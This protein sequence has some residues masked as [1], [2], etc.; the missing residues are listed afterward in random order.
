MKIL[1]DNGHGVET[2]GKRSPDGVLLEYQW[3]RQIA[4]RVVASLTDLGHDAQLLVPEQEDIPLSE[5]CRRVN[6]LCRSV[7][8]ENVI[9][10]PIHCNAVAADGKWHKATGWSAYTSRGNTK[11][12]AL[13]TCFYDAACFHLPGRRIITDYSDGNHDFEAPFYLLKNTIAAA[14]LTEN[15]YYDNPSDLRF[16]E[17]EEG[18]KAIVALHVEGV[19]NYL[20][21]MPLSH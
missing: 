20:N 9:L 11:A 5:R 19:V 8:K 6:D 18:Q 12:D 7:G 21:S 4:A 13:A 15:L 1:I 10:V 16:L 2:P 14:V 3:N 17:S